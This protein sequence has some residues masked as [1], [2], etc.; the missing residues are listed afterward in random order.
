MIRILRLLKIM[1]FV[2]Q[3][4]TINK[5]LEKLQLNAALTRL[6]TLILLE[7]FLVHIYSCLWF[8]AAKFDDFGPD[9]WI[10]R[11]DLQD[12]DHF[13]QYI[14]CVYWCFQTL[15]TVGYGDIPLMTVT[16]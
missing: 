16:E 8:I 11:N 10:A 3:N 15:T 4:V 13:E 6:I 5:F 9:T 14:W 1:K 2:K 7:I 12:S